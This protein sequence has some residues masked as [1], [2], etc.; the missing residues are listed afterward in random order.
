MRL[1][2][3]EYTDNADVFNR[4]NEGMFHFNKMLFN[5]HHKSYYHKDDKN[6][7][8]T[9]CSIAPTGYL[10]TGFI[11]GKGVEID[12]NKAYTKGTMDI[13]RIPIFCEFDIWKKYDCEKHDF[14]K[15][16]DL[17]LYYVKSR[18]KNM[19]FNRSYNLIYGKYLKIF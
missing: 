6:V 12:M 8:D 16:N 10:D 7:F 1:K 15:M 13:T 17:T 2:R 14:N 5:P 11:N 18:V 19:F 4:V 9:A 3:S